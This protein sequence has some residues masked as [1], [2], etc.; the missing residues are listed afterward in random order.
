MH[1]RELRHDVFAVALLTVTLTALLGGCKDEPAARAPEIQTAKL[2]TYV[3]SD[4]FLEIDRVYDDGC[5]PPDTPDGTCDAGAGETAANCPTDCGELAADANLFVGPDPVDSSPSVQRPCDI[6]CP[7]T[8]IWI[9]WE[10]RDPTRDI[11]DFFEVG[12]DPSAFPG[13][14]SCVDEANNPPKQELTGAAIL[15]NLSY[16][17]FALARFQ[18]N[19]DSAY[20]WVLTQVEPTQTFGATY[21]EYFSGQSKTCD[22]T[23]YLLAYTLTEGDIVL[24]GSFEPSAGADVMRVFQVTATPPAVPVDARSV[25]DFLSMVAAGHYVEVT[26]TG[27][28][29]AAINT[30]VASTDA[31]AGTTDTEF[32]ELTFSETAVPMDTLSG[33]SPDGACGLS[34][35][36]SAIS[37]PSTS[38]SSDMKDLIGPINTS[39]GV[40][41]VF[42]EFMQDC[43]GTGSS[44]NASYSVVAYGPGTD[45]DDPGAVP[46]VEGTEM[47]CAWEF[48]LG[49]VGGTPY[50]TSSTCNGTLALPPGSYTA[51]VTV[52]DLESE[53]ESR[54]EDGTVGPVNIEDCCPDGEYCIDDDECTYDDMCVDGEC[55]GTPEDPQI[56]TDEL[57]FFLVVEDPQQNPV[58][59]VRCTYLA[60]DIE[61]A[62]L[63][64]D[65][66]AGPL[67]PLVLDVRPELTCD[68]W[69]TP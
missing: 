56:C 35:W 17:Y 58:G 25:T 64:P 52:T 57:V 6:A 50:A 20:F 26:G 19:G 69:S 10:D 16:G 48:Y 66:G 65:P 31:F 29:V 2:I 7:A 49:P 18:G 62:T 11:D 41:S 24:V 12:K 42:P 37:K 5:D 68:Y 36:A 43:D 53:C 63:P 34:F 54:Q 13:S 47:T 3:G 8:P 9:D 44:E 4:V 61:C 30:T 27:E 1:L 51:V 45:P 14:D 67:D 55:V 39:L 40:V 23:E 46:L 60:P 38:A 28:A 15:S 22:P 33:N 21:T 59:S 32:S